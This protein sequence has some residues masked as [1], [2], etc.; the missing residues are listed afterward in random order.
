MKR[1]RLSFIVTLGAVM[2]LASP[3]FAAPAK[4]RLMN[5]KE[6]DAMFN[7]EDSVQHYLQQSRT[8]ERLLNAATYNFL[9]LVDALD[10]LD[11]RKGPR[12]QILEQTIDL[13]EEAQRA[14]P[15][16]NVIGAFLGDA[17]GVKVTFSGFPTLLVWAKKCQ[18]ALNRA[19]RLSNGDP[20]VRLL[21]LRSLVHFPYQYYPDLRGQNV[22]DA[23]AVQQWIA[24]VQ[25]AG[26]ND[27]EMKKIYDDYLVDVKNEVHY[28][29]G[30]YLSEQAKDNKA[31]IAEL[32]SADPNCWKYCAMA[33][34]LLVSLQ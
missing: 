29:L 34:R 10:K 3:L 4:P 13:L 32:K 24:D 9:N 17:Y 15:N 19:V 16:D 28:I 33:H 14:A 8:P 21:R 1:I 22:D 23:N 30:Q 7:G 27:P 11:K 20:E 26:G 12:K 5:P 31:A 2:A 25:R 6:L 18:T